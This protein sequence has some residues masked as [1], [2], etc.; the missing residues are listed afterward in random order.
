[1]MIKIKDNITFR[2]NVTLNEKKKRE[3]NF[4]K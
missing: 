4:E 1:M 2:F 3:G